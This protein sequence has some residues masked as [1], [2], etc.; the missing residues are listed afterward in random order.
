ML[1][2]DAAK[3]PAPHMF[4]CQRQRRHLSEDKEIIWKGK[5]RDSSK[6][7]HW[8]SQNTHAIILDFAVQK[9]GL[10]FESAMRASVMKRQRTLLKGKMEAA[11]WWIEAAICMI[12]TWFISHRL[13]A[14]KLLCSYYPCGRS[15][16][17]CRCFRNLMMEGAILSLMIGGSHW[18]F[19][20]GESNEWWGMRKGEHIRWKR[21]ARYRGW[22]EWGGG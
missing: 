17:V 3:P 1:F 20:H 19:K 7:R 4:M 15:R 14:T 21:C 6:Q 18:A 8:R 12:E 22:E 11:R 2:G 13:S 5:R 9:F 16:N 10:G